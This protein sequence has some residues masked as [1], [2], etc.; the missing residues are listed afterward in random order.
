VSYFDQR[1]GEFVFRPGPVFAHVLLVDEI[2]RA[3]PRTQ[4]ALLEAMAE[5][6]YKV[7]RATLVSSY[8]LW[9]FQRVTRRYHIRCMGRGVSRDVYAEREG[10]A[11][12]AAMKTQPC[13]GGASSGRMG[14]PGNSAPSRRACTYVSGAV[15]TLWRRSTGS[16]SCPPA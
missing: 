1:K 16:S 13:A 6:S 7:N 10:S 4:S 11:W 12:T 2:N 9:S 8:S 14:W 5:P 3:T 15:L